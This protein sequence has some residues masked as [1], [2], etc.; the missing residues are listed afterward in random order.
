MTRNGQN[1]NGQVDI[2][3]MEIKLKL[4]LEVEAIPR[5]GQIKFRT[6][7]ERGH[8]S[9]ALIK[10]RKLRVPPVHNSG[11]YFFVANKRS[12]VSARKQERERE[13]E[14]Q[15]REESWVYGMVKV[16]ENVCRHHGS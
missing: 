15:N 6:R 10:L 8:N 1:V 16:D 11:K 9:V 2:Y 12:F 7:P 3:Q 5:L 13:L 4:F 14:E